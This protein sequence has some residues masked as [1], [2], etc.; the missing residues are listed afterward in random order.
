MG[1]RRLFLVID[2]K[3]VQLVFQGWLVDMLTPGRI[4]KSELLRRGRGDMVVRR[5]L[6]VAPKRVYEKLSL[7]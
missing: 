3:S 4:G 7:C 2:Q 1:Y 6:A 5:R